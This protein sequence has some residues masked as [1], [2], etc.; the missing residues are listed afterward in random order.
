MNP[1]LLRAP[2]SSFAFD[3]ESLRLVRPI[4]LDGELIGGVY[5]ESGLDGLHERLRR[6]LSIIAVVLFGALALAFVLSSKLQ[7]LISA[8][9]LRLTE[10]MQVVS[11]DRNYDIRVEKTGR[12]EVGVLIDGFNEMLLE[13]QRRD[14][15]LLEQQEAL[16]QEVDVRTG[17][18]RAANAELLTARDKAM[19]GSRAKSE[20][21]ANMSHEIRTPMNGIIGMTELALDSTVDPDQRG[22]LET[23]KFSA[24]SLLTLLNDILDFSKIESQKLELETT[25]FSVVDSDGRHVEAAGLAGSHERPRADRR[26][27]RRRSSGDRRGS[28]YASVRSLPIWSATRSSSRRRATCWC[29]CAVKSGWAI[30]CA[31]TCPSAIPASA[32]PRTST[33]PSSRRSA[34]RTDRP[35]GASAD[36]AGPDD[37]ARRSCSSCMGGHLG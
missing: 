17:D 37:F 10:V 7:R 25:Q 9:V 8:P 15:Q 16:E 35:R 30:A 27:R 23:V 1:E 28:G 18:L 29:R 19:E 32:F 4:L 22:C 6:L 5:I 3:R 34:R 24:S 2:R 14:R 31:C 33:P 11:R 12:D 26:R 36:R 21:L 13:I 20:F